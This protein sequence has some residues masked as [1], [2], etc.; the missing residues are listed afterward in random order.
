MGTSRA[1]PSPAQWGDRVLRERGPW[2]TFV[3]SPRSARDL[4]QRVPARSCA[5]SVARPRHRASQRK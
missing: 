5:G 4:R 3:A 1:P 2:G